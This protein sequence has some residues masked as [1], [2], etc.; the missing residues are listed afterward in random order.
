MTAEGAGGD[1]DRLALSCVGRAVVAADGR[2]TGRRACMWSPP[3]VIGHAGDASAR[4]EP[5]AADLGMGREDDRPMDRGRDREPVP[6][7]EDRAAD[8]AVEEVVPGVP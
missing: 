4:P 5:V 3:L 6:R 2:L 7:V 1:V 8:D